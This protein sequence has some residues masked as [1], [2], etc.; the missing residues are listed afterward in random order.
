MPTYGEIVKRPEVRVSL[1]EDGSFAS[2]QMLV[3][4]QATR[5]GEKFGGRVERW[6][7]IEDQAAL[8]A[9]LGEAAV[10]QRAH[11]DAVE[12]KIQDERKAKADEHAELVRQHAA[13]MADKEA[14]LAALR[15]PE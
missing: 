6:E 13:A 12:K 2:A 8:I 5:D 15:S 7:R 1:Y 11:V 14:E 4:T 10:T 3:V 9:L